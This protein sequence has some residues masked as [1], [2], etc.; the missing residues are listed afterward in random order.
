MNHNGMSTP[1]SM[2]ATAVS[3]SFDPKLTPADGRPAVANASRTRHASCVSE[4]RSSPIAGMTPFS[5]PATRL[6]TTT[7]SALPMWTLWGV[8]TMAT[9]GLAAANRRPSSSIPARVLIAT[10]RSSGVHASAMAIPPCGAIAAK[11]NG[12]RGY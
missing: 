4:T 1:Q 8:A 5:L 7:P 11:T 10:S 3:G 12:M 2:G 6:A 9:S